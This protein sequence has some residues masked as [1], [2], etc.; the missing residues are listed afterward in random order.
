M[1]HYEFNWWNYYNTLG[2]GVGSDALTWVMID[3]QQTVYV[4]SMNRGVTRFQ[5]PATWTIWD[6]MSSPMPD[7][8]GQC[9]TKENNHIVW[10]GTK[11]GGLVRIDENP[12]GINS[13]SSDNENTVSCYPNPARAGGIISFNTLVNEGTYYEL[14]DINGRVVC[15]SVVAANTIQ[16]PLEI[17]TGVYVLRLHVSESEQRT[18]KLLI[19]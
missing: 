6:T 11:E 1:L 15:A 5:Q 19:R 13:I 2:S 10:V 17:A 18:V 8:Y 9:V 4:T 16:L 3:S 7:T 14:C 12:V